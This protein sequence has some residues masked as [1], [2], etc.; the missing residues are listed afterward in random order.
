MRLKLTLTLGAMLLAAPAYAVM[1]TTQRLGNFTYTNCDDG[2][3][4]TGQ[5]LGRFHYD[6]I[7]PPP[8]PVRPIQP[9]QPMFPNT[10]GTVPSVPN[11]GWPR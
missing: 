9:M 10:F 1:C 2:T 6:N 8:A 11:Y 4:V 7:L 3:N 5:D